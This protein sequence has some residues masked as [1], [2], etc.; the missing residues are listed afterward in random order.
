[1]SNQKLIHGLNLV[2][3]DSYALYLKTQ[4]YHW[5]VTGQNFASLHS[6]FEEQ[7]KDLAEAIDEI[8]ERIRVLGPRV[9]ATFS[10]FDQQSTI[11]DGDENSNAEH[12]L[13]DLIEDN[14]NI[15]DILYKAADLAAENNDKAT[16]DLCVERI[17]IHEKN[18]WMLSASH[19]YETIKPNLD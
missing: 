19:E 6:M 18:A 17:H 15:V 9:A 8:A 16:E 13:K 14:K 12:M 3:A 7:Y 5:N 10:L 1:M 2:L 11:P 4:N